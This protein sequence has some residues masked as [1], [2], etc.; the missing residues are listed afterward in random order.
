MLL[1][2]RR[3]LEAVAGE[4][5]SAV[6]SRRILESTGLVEEDLPLAGRRGGGRRAA[7]G[8]DL[9]LRGLAHDARDGRAQAHDL[10]PL[11][12]CGRAVTQLMHGVEQALDGAA[13][14]LREDAGREVDRYRV[15]LADIAHV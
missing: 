9:A 5:R 12:R 13:I 6:V 8:L 2:Q 3:P 1:D 7:S 14:A 10:G 11:G 4:E 15:L